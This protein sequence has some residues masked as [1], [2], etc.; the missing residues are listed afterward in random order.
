MHILDAR[1]LA[2]IRL[3]VFVALPNLQMLIRLAHKQDLALL[4]IRRIRK[5]HQ[6]TF[7]LLNAAQ[8]KQIGIRLHRQRAI[9][10]GR[11]HIIGIHHRQRLRRHLRRQ[12]FTVF[13]KKFRFDRLMSHGNWCRQS[14]AKPAQRQRF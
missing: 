3:A 12:A 6:N 10:I 2:R 8:E 4:L 13:G 7:L 1:D 5:E 11:Q 9:G 14:A